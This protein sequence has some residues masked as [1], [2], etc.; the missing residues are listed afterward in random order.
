M[1]QTHDF[2]QHDIGEFASSKTCPYNVP[3][4]KNAHYLLTSL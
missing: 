2:L 3:G 4:Q 1:I